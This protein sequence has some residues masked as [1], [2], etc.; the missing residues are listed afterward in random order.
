MDDRKPF[1]C[2]YLGQSQ[3]GSRVTKRRKLESH[4]VVGTHTLCTWFLGR[5]VNVVRVLLGR[6]G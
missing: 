2:N 5:A 4:L 6:M 1:D 3:K